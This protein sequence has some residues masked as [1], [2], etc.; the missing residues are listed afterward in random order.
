MTKAIV[1]RT[2]GGPEVLK[3]EDVPLGPPGPGEVQIRQAAI[4]LNFIDVYFR[5]G[6]Y[7]AE[8]PFV[9]GKEGAGTVTRISLSAIAWP[10]R[11]PMV[12]MRRSATWRHAISSGFRKASRSKRPPP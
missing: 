6:L 11:L 4:G 9:P 7:K 3:L 2:L 12:P 5:T 1:I 8:P 10:M